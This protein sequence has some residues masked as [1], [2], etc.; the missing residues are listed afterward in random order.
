MKRLVMFALLLLCILY[1]GDYVSVRYRIPNNRSQFGVV[2]VRRYYAVGLKSG[3][4]EYM[5]L[6]GKPDVR[7]LS[8]SSLRLRPM[9]VPQSQ[10]R[11]TDQY[12]KD[13]ADT[14]PL[15]SVGHICT[16]GQVGKLAL[17]RR[18][19]RGWTAAGVFQPGWAV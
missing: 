5:F 2:K 12:V 13:T 8:V 9:L 4:T 19:N 16:Q 6:A 1:I 10:K 15:L 14:S 17:C 11:K 3:K 7:S 18:G